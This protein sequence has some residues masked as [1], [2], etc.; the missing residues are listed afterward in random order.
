MPSS[1]HVLG[2]GDEIHNLG[3]LRAHSLVG[4]Y[5]EVDNYNTGWMVSAVCVRGK[6]TVF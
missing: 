2:F 4:G 3:L 6:P 5:K 1:I